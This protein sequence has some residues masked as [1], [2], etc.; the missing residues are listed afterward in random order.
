VHY[1]F[2]AWSGV[3]RHLVAA[4][5][6]S[7]S[8]NLDARI[9]YKPPTGLQYGG[10]GESVGAPGEAGSPQSSPSSS[11]SDLTSPTFTRD[12]DFDFSNQENYVKTNALVSRANNT[13]LRVKEGE[14]ILGYRQDDPPL[15]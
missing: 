9:I 13:D 12:P 2:T 6:M 10:S 15:P 5:P 7:L 14:E 4:V 3:P 8:S 1:L 11:H